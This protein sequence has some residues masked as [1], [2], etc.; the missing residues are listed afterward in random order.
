MTADPG[1][2]GDLITIERRELHLI[3]QMVHQAYHSR[4]FPEGATATWRECSVGVCGRIRSILDEPILGQPLSPRHPAGEGDAERG[5]A[6][7]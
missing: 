7:K 4:L 2:T 5:E 3:A 1:A 6:E